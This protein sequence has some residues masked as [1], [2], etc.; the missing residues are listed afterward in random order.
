MTDASRFS[1][2]A[3][4]F[5]FLAG[6][7][8][9]VEN[10][11]ELNRINVFPVAD[12]DTGTNLATTVR[13]IMDHVRPTASYRETIDAIAQAALE[14]AVGNSGI[15]FAQYLYGLSVESRND[16]FSGMVQAL[17]NAVRY[18][19]EAVADPRE[20]TMITVIREWTDFL[21]AQQQN[22]PN[23][24]DLWTRSLER[25]RQSLAE[26]T[27]KLDVLS[28]ARV[29]DAG[30]MGMVLFLEGLVD[31]LK[32][33]TF[34][35]A[36]IVLPIFPGQDDDL[37]TGLPDEISARFC[38]EAILKGKALDRL[39]IRRTVEDLGDSLAVAGSDKIMRIHIHTDRPSDLF[40]RL[41]DFGTISCQKADDM[42]LQLD[43]AHRRKWNIALLTDSSCDL[44]Q[45]L[46][47]H[48]QIHV[49]PLHLFFGENQYLDKLTIT[50]DQFY[51]MLEQSPVFPT[52]S[53]PTVKTFQ[54]AY[55]HLASH[56]DSVI[57][58]HLTQKFSGTFSNSLKAAERISKEMNK[59]ISVID[60]QHLSGSLGLLVLKTAR[61]VAQGL[62]HVEIVDKM[63][64]WI[65]KT[66]LYVGVRTLKYM[67][68]SG[69]VSPMKGLIANLLNL[70]PIVTLENGGSRLLDKSFSR[71]G[72][73]KKIINRITGTRVHDYCILH[74][75]ESEG[76]SQ[77]ASVLEN[78]TGKK[79]V[80]TMDISPAIGLHAGIGCVAVGLMAE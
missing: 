18:M 43:S 20:G 66:R 62:P 72:S 36:Y 56:Y 21:Q 2:K 19:M 47:D 54:T 5:G 44:P 8:K 34:R 55:G 80:F 14:G 50:T 46:I 35:K 41:K 42:R 77:M 17:K 78:T 45:E 71:K 65:S 51:S 32:K 63:R 24:L 25:A 4:F 22:V 68:K 64:D 26:T 1:G 12:A 28:K 6:A 61:A 74:A 27:K 29:V 58:L 39:R 48:Y 10:Q 49:V 76:A 33:P 59:P 37:T 31:F 52:T 70:K 79:A 69:R 7:K 13:Y 16:T 9:I 11:H 23:W 60:S 3:F 40:H 73:M 57:S 15:I 38:T 75:H 67:V 30:S 53:Q